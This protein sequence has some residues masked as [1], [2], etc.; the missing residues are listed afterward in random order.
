MQLMP[1]CPPRSYLRTVAVL[2]T[3]AGFGGAHAPNARAQTFS[4]YSDFQAMSVADMDSLRIKLT[5][6]GPQDAIQLTLVLTRAG[7]P[8]EITGFTPFRRSDFDYS[9]DDGPVGTSEA[10]RQELKATID[11]VGTL[12]RVTAGGVDSNGYVSFAMLSTAGGGAKVFEAI[13]NDTTGAELFGKI[14]SALKNNTAATRDVRRFGCDAGMLLKE[15]P[16]NVE[17]QVAVTF[18]GLRADRNAKTGSS[19]RLGFRTS[20]D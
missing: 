3:F 15:L 14:L 18:S 17:N 11:S 19:E 4:P 9:N 8:V 2:V 13:V 12:P 7:T 20:Q 6:G 5:Y 16:T 1:L 10:S